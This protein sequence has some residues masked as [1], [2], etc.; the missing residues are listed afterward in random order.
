MLR[1]DPVK[2]TFHYQLL[3]A[4]E[5]L[6]G[7]VSNVKRSRKVS[8]HEDLNTWPAA[9]KASATRGKYDISFIGKTV[10][11]LARVTTSPIYDI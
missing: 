9:C 7:L 11:R 2:P 3:R 5:S 1:N 6:Y 10:Q 8:F 4:M